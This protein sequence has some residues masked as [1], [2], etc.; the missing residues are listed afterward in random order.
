MRGYNL[1]EHLGGE[2]AEGPGRARYLAGMNT[3]EG[4]VGP[5]ILYI[6]EQLARLTPPVAPAVV[7]GGFDHQS[8]H[9][10]QLHCRL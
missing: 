3:L 6:R 8:F 1:H 2:D 10:G 5:R 9:V 4:R 7:G